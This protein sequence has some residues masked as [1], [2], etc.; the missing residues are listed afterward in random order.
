MVAKSAPWWLTEILAV[1]AGL[2]VKV[3]NLLLSLLPVKQAHM[4]ETWSLLS[5]GGN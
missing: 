5:A 4:W 3:L 2:E 1:R